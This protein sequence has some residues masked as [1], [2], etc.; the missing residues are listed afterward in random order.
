[1]TNLLVTATIPATTGLPQDA[2]VAS[3]PF[4]TNLGV[5][6]GTFDIVKNAI[7]QFLNANATGQIVNVA[8]YLSAKLDRTANAVILR[9]YNLTGNL[10]GSPHGSPTHLGTLTLGP[11]ISGNS[12]PAQIASVL[13]LRGRGAA[14][15][16]V[17][18]AGGIRP[19]ARHTGRLFLGPLTVNAS[20]GGDYPRPTSQ[21]RLD[22]T[23]A[24]EKL[25]DT[26]TDGETEWAVWSRR[27]AQMFPVVSVE[28]DDSF[29]VIRSRKPKPTVRTARVF[30]PVPA[31]VLG[32]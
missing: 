26:M 24:A 15:A 2:V 20:S 23:A 11:A 30:A 14:T 16:A 4:V 28:M 3:F 17:E 1:M 9:M 19:K 12:L 29:D 5:G 18:G 7:D 31:L 22:C 27:E 10:D 6:D 8:G 21:F 25:Q 13:T 32:A